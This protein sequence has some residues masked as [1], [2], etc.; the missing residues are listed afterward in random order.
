MDLIFA[1]NLKRL[2]LEKGI[3]QEELAA[4]LGLSKQSVSKWERSEGYPD[5]TLLPKIAAYFHVTVDDLLGCGQVRINEQLA[6]W[7]KKSAVLCHER[8][9]VENLALWEN[10]YREMPEEE[11][12][13]C[14]LMR[15]LLPMMYRTEKPDSDRF[16]Q[17]IL[18]LAGVLLNMTKDSEMRESAVQ[19]LCFASA[20]LGD[21]DAAR[22][23]AGLMG[24][25]TT[26]QGEL[27]ALVLSGEEAAVQ[28]QNNL[29]DLLFCCILNLEN[30]LLHGKYTPAEEIELSRKKVR[31][32]EAFF[33]DG[34]YGFY[35]NTLQIAWSDIAWNAARLQ[36]VSLCL[37][38]LSNACDA[39]IRMDTTGSRAY[40]SLAM[41]RLTYTASDTTPT[42]DGN[43]CWCVLERMN[44]DCF[45]FIRDD[46]A[47]RQIRETLE[48]YAVCY[49]D[50]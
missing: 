26:T 12:V 3:T 10:A 27:M 13:L 23:Y 21:M 33:E 43:D 1:E 38:A 22:K 47:F 16:G 6:E 48:P 46:P 35:N 36:D 19:H 37:S 30:L 39:A 4:H 20:H 41:N 28:A 24:S 8:R 5:I 14:G 11:T 18:E 49:K 50:R 15:A 7:K 25:Y 44:M 32:I 42:D 9:E 34:N 40:T 45:N 2:R 17:R 29:F 31:L